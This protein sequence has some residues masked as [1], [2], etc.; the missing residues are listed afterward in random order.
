M[1]SLVKWYG[2]CV[3]EEGEAF[4]GYWAELRW[5]G[6]HIRYASRL[7]ANGDRTT[8]RA[9]EGPVQTGGGYQWREPSIGIEGRWTPIVPA[10]SA[11]VYADQSGG[12]EWNCVAPAARARVDGREGLGYLER[13]EM[14]VAPWALPIETLLWGRYLAHGES[15][16]WI[17]WRGKFERRLVLRNG[18]AVEAE[19][20]DEAG[21]RLRSGE[22]YEFDRGRTLRAGAIG[23]NVLSKI[24]GV[25]Q[26]APLRLMQIEEQKWLSR[27]RSL[28]GQ[29]VA[30]EGWAIHEVVT[31]P[32]R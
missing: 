18:L 9:G 21:L 28:M 24:P 6:L 20:I 30:S 11:T 25:K 8:L 10:Y 27:G 7:G 1:F 29:R 15:V 32:P 4:V 19:Q 26:L 16:V 13:I 2:D 3:S 14:T 31:W 5:R 22:T 17:D 23:A 12:I